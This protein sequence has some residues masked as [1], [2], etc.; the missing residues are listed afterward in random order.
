ML[1][2]S[3]GKSNTPSSNF[4]YVHPPSHPLP[5]VRPSRILALGQKRVRVRE[6][7]RDSVVVVHDGAGRYSGDVEQELGNV[8][9]SLAIPET[10]DEL[11]EIAIANLQKYEPQDGYYLAFSGGKDSTVI[12]DLAVRAMVKFDAHY[13]FT[14][15]DPPELVRHI[16]MHYPNIPWDRPKKSMFQLIEGRGFLPTRQIR[17]CCSELKEYGGKGRVVITGVR[18]EESRK[19]SDRPLYHMDTRNKNT[20]YLNP[21]VDWKDKTVWDYIH[22]HNLQYC[23]LYDEGFDRIGCIMCPLQGSKQMERERER[24]PKFYNAYL[25]AI[26]RGLERAKERGRKSLVSG[27]TAEDTMRWWIYAE[28]SPCGEQCQLFG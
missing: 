5:R 24:W 18:R 21:I 10:L 4:F 27:L 6:R 19:R 1:Q 28:K 11:I 8:Q 23:S 14:T 12:Y 7:A 15:V 13:H 22:K 26:R 3:A 16:K 2:T 20:A 17:Y 9:Q 25:G